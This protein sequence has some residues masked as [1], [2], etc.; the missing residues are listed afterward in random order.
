MISRCVVVVAATCT[1]VLSLCWQGLVRSTVVMQYPNY[2]HT[3]T[4]LLLEMIAR[5]LKHILRSRLR[6]CSANSAGST[7][8]ARKHAHLLRQP[9]LTVRGV[10]VRWPYFATAR[11]L[12]RTYSSSCDMF[13]RSW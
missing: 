5:S 1:R 2:E 6:R 8:G 13:W 9:S 3:L 7:V 10:F 12:A 4:L 11:W